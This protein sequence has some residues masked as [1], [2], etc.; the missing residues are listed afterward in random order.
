MGH[1]SFIAIAN[2]MKW[3][4]NCPTSPLPYS[5]DPQTRHD[6][7]FHNQSTGSPGPSAFKNI[8]Q[9]HISLGIGAVGA[10]T[11]GFWGSVPLLPHVCPLSVQKG[12][13]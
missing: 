8:L 5:F 4:Q 10:N 2:A 1:H 9:G 6:S 3:R 7:T 12:G 13:L 11:E